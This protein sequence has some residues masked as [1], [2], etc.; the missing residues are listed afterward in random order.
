MES[1]KISHSAFFGGV[2]SRNAVFAGTMSFGRSKHVA[3]L[4]RFSEQLKQKLKSIGRMPRVYFY[5]FLLLLWV[6][7]GDIICWD[8]PHVEDRGTRRARWRKCMISYV[9]CCF[10]VGSM[11]SV[12]RKRVCFLCLKWSVR[13]DVVTHR[14]SKSYHIDLDVDLWVCRRSCILWTWGHVSG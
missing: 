6:L 9:L 5:F 14:K 10:F 12:V 7:S 2:F 13:K 11:S 3:R 1:A 8:C 4:R